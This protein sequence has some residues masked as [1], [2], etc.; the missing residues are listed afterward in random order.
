MKKY[1]PLLT[2]ILLA[3]VVQFAAGQQFKL[4]PS[5]YF[6]NKGVDVMAFD[7]IYPEGHQGGVSLIMHGNR[8]GTNGD[9]RFEPTPGQW[10]PVPKQND[11]KVDA[12]ANTITAFLSYPD[13]SRHLTG[14]NPMIYPDM[15]FNYTVTVKGEG[16]AVV[17]TVDLDRPIPSQF[18]G[19][20]GFNFELFPGALFGKAWIMDKQTGIFPQ[21]PN[22]PTL[23]EKANH[24]HAGNFNPEGK[25]SAKHL[26]GKGYSPIIADDIIAEPYA[27]GK[28][29]TVR[30]DDPYNRFTIESK[31][32]DLKLFDGRMNHN[33]GW[34]VVRS[35]I[36]A[37]ATKE[38]IK[39]VI[40]PNVVEDWLYTPI[41]QTSQLG[42][43]PN[44]PKVAIIE[45]DKRDTKREKPI[46][47]R[48]TDSGEKEVTTASGNEWGQFLRYNYVKFDFSDVK[49]EGLY[50]VK[51]GNSYSAIFRI[52]KDVYDR[53]AWQPVLEY[54][55]PVQMCHM[56]VNE[57][58]RVWHGHCHADDARMAPVN[59]NH[60]DGYVQGPST[61]TKYKPGDVVP[62]LNIGGWHDAGDFD[63]RVESQAG[64]TYILAL[65]YEAFGV[66]YDATSIDQI[67]RI[68]EIHQ[69]DGKADML[70]QVEN[71]ALS[72]VGAYR[73]LGRLYR[74]IICNDLRQ[75]VLLGDAMTMT[76]NVIGNEDD[77]W[78]FT[79]DNPFRELSTSAHLAA[80]ARV[81]KGFNDTLSIQSLEAA[82]EIYKVTKVTDR[83]K[84]AKIQAATELYIATGDKEYKDYLLSETD[85]IVKN[86]GRI[87]W[88]IGRAEKKMSDKKFTKAVREALTGFRAELEKQGA[89]TPYGIPYRPH[90]WGAG[91]NIQSF[92]YRHYFLHTAYPDIFSSDF[93]Y[94][95]LNFILGCH[96]GTNTSSFASGIGARSATV[97]YGLNRADWSYIPGGVV[98]GTALIRPDFPELLEF[99]FLWQQVEYVMGGGSS[100]Y[101]FLVL[102]A[103]QLLS[104]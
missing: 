42:Y 28:R 40:T 91:W 22:G 14:F 31:G 97:G 3:F 55:L 67:N 45:L 23:S 29:F 63:L 74:G 84:S 56:R 10:Q 48:I 83:V 89:E 50:Q 65:A 52:A 7:D 16:N 41:V 18:I 77:R 4:I 80:A 68:T 60:I 19:K 12:S 35:E 59:F 57:K 37:G 104:K 93:V 30:P 25:A 33:N 85:Y 32:T 26:A 102:A 82:R 6:Q 39:W 53:G 81:L 101:M 62:G 13:S 75:Y 44:Q 100:H 46:L 78:V 94:N 51:Y 9:I 70:Q 87:G 79:E 43:H 38:A 11:R 103:Q 71:G 54:F 90:I 5:G 36:A 72:V 58:Y 66:D 20:V 8:V 98:S 61:L 15:Q 47:Y 73:A 64:E 99:P 49:E 1:K 88:F 76:D 69:P 92:G 34:F 17:V 86:I 21:Q 95:A 96:P 24:N 27:V 2:A